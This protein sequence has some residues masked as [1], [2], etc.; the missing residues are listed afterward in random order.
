MRL[1]R[2]VGVVLLLSF[3]IVAADKTPVFSVPLSIKVGLWHMTYTTDRNGI[4]VTHSFPPELLAKMTPEQR[5]KTEARLKAKATQG[6]QAENREY[7]LTEERLRNAVFDPTS[8][9][10]ACQRTVIVSTGKVQQFH[11][12]CADGSSKRSID[13]H[14]EG[15]DTDTMR[16]S[17][18][19]KSEGPS[20]YTMN[21]EIAGR[22]IAADCGNEAQ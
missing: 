1:C 11:E 4:A 8:S 7:C 15:V 16:G 3:G 18:K 20:V 6:A 9:G 13:G 12:E 5:A 17:L 10:V 2:T 14:F 21:I 19:V 22:W